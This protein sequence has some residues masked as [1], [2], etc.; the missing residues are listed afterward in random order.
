MVGLLGPLSIDESASEETTMRVMEIR[1]A[2]G[3]ENLKPGD[4]PDPTPGSGEVV[5]RIDAASVNYP[6]FVMA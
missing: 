1:D 3:L 5:I 2:W 6:D 4:R